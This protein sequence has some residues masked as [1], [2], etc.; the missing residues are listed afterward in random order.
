MLTHEGYSRV[1]SG[2]FEKTPDGHFISPNKAV[3]IFHLVGWQIGRAMEL[4]PHLQQYGTVDIFLSGANS[5]LDLDASVKYRSKGL[6]LY[7]NCTGGLDYWQMIKGYQP[8]RVK[9]EIQELPVEK[10]DLVLNDFEYITAASCAKTTS[11]TISPSSRDFMPMLTN[12]STSATPQSS[13][14]T[15]NLSQAHHAEQKK[16]L[17]LFIDEV[18]QAFAPSSEKHCVASG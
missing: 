2:I 17:R 16:S 3:G 10:Y 14:P 4:L 15:V 18:M 11:P 13:T 12:G 8:F 9:K 1:L 7:Y 5:S 6:S